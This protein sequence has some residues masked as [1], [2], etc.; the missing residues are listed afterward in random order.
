VQQ[1]DVRI[2]ALDDFAIEL[3]HQPQHAVRRRVLGAKIH[4]VVT[5]L[6]HLSGMQMHFGA[7]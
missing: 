3:E 2:G 4:R 7:G 5:D 1:A 6:G